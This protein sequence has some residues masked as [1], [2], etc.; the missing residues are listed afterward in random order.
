M[1]L[2]LG[3]DYRISAIGAIA[4]SFSSYLFIII[5]AG[6]MTKAHAIAYMPMVVAAVLYTYRGKIL[7]GGL[8]TAL[9]V[10]LQLYANHLQITYYL[11]LILLFIGFTELVKSIKTNNLID[12]LKRFS[13]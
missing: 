6:H 3:V 12:F 10:S 4:F 9:A 8:L 5:Q 1:L 13:T 7:L 2:S 11:I